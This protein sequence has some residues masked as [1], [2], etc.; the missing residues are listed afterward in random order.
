M[1]AAA[2][3]KPGCYTEFLESPF[4][5]AR[6]LRSFN[7][8]VKSIGMGGNNKELGDGHLLALFCRVRDFFRFVEQ[9]LVRNFAR[10]LSMGRLDGV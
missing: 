10:N 7:G 4:F 9:K 1:P 8:L 6:I 5:R 3:I 2:K